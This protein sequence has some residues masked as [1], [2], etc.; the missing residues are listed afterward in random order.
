MHTQHTILTIAGS[1]S[2]GGAGIQADLRTFAA[3]G[4]YGTSAITALTAQNTQGVQAVHGV[5]PA[6]VQQQIQSV[7]DDFDV[8]AIKTGMLFN[9]DNTRATVEAL[10]THFSGRTMPPLVCDPVCVSTSGHSLLAPEAIQVLIHELLPLTTLIT[11]NKSEAELLLSRS[12]TSL[13]DMLEATKDLI[14]L[15]PKAVLLKGGHITAKLSDLGRLLSAHPEA[16]VVRDGMYGDK[17]EILAVNGPQFEYLV[18]D[19]LR[20]ADDSVTVLARPR[21][22]SSSTHGTGCTLSAALASALADGNTLSEAV[23]KATAFTHL[24]IATA[25]T[26][27]GSGQGPLNHLHSVAQLSVPPRTPG[28]P[29]PFTKLLITGSA[30]IWKEYVEHEFVQLLGKGTLPRASFVQ[31]IVQDYHYLKYY[32]RAYSLLAAKSPSFSRIGSATQTIGHILREIE[33]HRA[34]CGE[35]GVSTDE[36]ESTPESAATTAYGCYLMDIGIQGDATKL[37]MALLACL[38]GYG[39]VGLW[40]KASASWVILEGNPYRRWIED[41]SG[42][43]H[44]AAVRAGLETIEEAAASN[45][46]SPGLLAEWRAVWDRCTKLETAFWDSALHLKN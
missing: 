23:M 32:A 22:D 16:R 40:L 27:L 38:L 34:F 12:I 2:G 7:L 44:Q 30:A 11:P 15:G 18:V 29:Y 1:D 39:E 43:E 19:V 17:M 8:H 14:R 9:A 6:F 25:Y 10:K 41:Y 36:L 35:F 46:P 42:A 24:G 26:N 28:N 31:F 21:I 13:E 3:L 4:N 20:E 33:T 37:L 5:P 45:P